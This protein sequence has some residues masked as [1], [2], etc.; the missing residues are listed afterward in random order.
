MIDLTGVRFDMGQIA[1]ISGV[2]RAAVGNWRSR[3]DDFPV[4]DHA[5]LYD[6]REVEDWLITSGRKPDRFDV[7]DIVWPLMDAVRSAGLTVDEARRAIPAL[8]AYAAANNGHM[9]GRSSSHWIH[10]CKRVNLYSRHQL[11]IQ[12]R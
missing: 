12:L 10:L 6:A 4:P 8:T 2:T 9:V 11:Y 7:S 3:H 1:E 5:G